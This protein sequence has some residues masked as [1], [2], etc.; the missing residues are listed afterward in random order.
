M[1]T[2]PKIHI[3]YTR[4]CILYYSKFLCTQKYHTPLEQAI[5]SKMYI[6]NIVVPYHGNLLDLRHRNSHL[7]LS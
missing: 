7:N 3:T 6:H 1:G 5:R 4:P 2:I